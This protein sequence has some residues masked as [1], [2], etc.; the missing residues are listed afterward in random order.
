MKKIISILSTL[1]ILSIQIQAQTVE[2]VTGIGGQGDDS[3]YN[4][5]IDSDNNIYIAGFFSGEVDFDPGNDD[6]FLTSNNTIDLFLLKLNSTGGFEWVEIM[7]GFY[8]QDIAITVDSSNNIIV[9]YFNKNDEGDTVVKVKKYSS[10]GSIIWQKELNWFGHVGIYKPSKILHEI[11]VID[12]GCDE[13]YYD[14]PLSI[15]GNDSICMITNEIL[16]DSGFVSYDLYCEYGESIKIIGEVYGTVSFEWGDTLFT[17]G[18]GEFFGGNYQRSTFLA[19]IKRNGEL[20]DIRIINYGTDDVG[21]SIGYGV[22]PVD[23]D[24]DSEGNIFMVARPLGL[25]DYGTGSNITSINHGLGA[26]AVIQKFSPNGEL[27][28]VKD[29]DTPQSGWYNSIKLNSLDEVFIGGKVSG[30]LDADPNQGEVIIEAINTTFGNLFVLKLDN[31][32]NYSWSKDFGF[33]IGAIRIDNEDNIFVNG[34]YSVDVDVSTINGQ[35]TLSPNGFSDFFTL[36]ISDGTSTSIETL[37]EIVDAQVFPNPSNKLVWIELDKSY[38]EVVINI[39]SSKGRL[40]SSSREYHSNQLKFSADN[41]PSGL[42]LIRIE[43][44]GEKIIN[45]KIII[46]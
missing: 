17:I 28:W 6:F 14:R 13:E 34:S 23:M 29:L 41:L 1:F 25:I 2:W 19:D 30:T 10:S 24:M 42:Y 32:G 43:L 27:L 37:N 16:D 9:E 4:F 21:S 7:D 39:F 26:G 20:N 8:S 22:Y 46:E 15:I 45:K 18:E 38:G 35:V 36:K 40:I 11:C 33:S 3:A 31:D 12:V 44:D 5:A